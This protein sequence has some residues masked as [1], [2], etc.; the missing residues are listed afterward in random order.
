MLSVVV[1]THH[2]R[3]LGEAV[4]SVLDQTEPDFEI[5][6]VP[7]GD[8]SVDGL[9]PDDSRIRVVP[10]PGHGTLGAIKR[11]GFEAA[12]GDILVELDHDDILAP[13]ALQRVREACA[14]GGAD[15]VYSNFAELNFQT[16]ECVTYDPYW[17][18]KTRSTEVRGRTVT[19]MMAFEPSPASIGRIW[20]APNHVRAWTREAYGRAGGHNPALPVCDDHDLLVRTYLTGRMTRI[21]ECLY[22]QRNHPARTTV[23]HNVDIQRTTEEIYCRSIESLVARW[24]AVSGLPCYQLGGCEHAAPGWV[25]IDRGGQPGVVDLKGRWPWDDS[26]VGAFGALDLLQYLPD[27]Q[28]AMNEMYRCL[29]PG[30]W[31]LSSTPSALGQAAFMDPRICSTWV[32]NSFY[33]WTDATYA[34]HIGNRS[35]GFRLIAWTSRS[36]P[37]GIGP[38]ACPTCTSTGWP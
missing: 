37:T 22:L 2:P 29:A 16:G 4:A 20:Y 12:A 38:S 36:H 28:H 9:L 23:A 1:P 21:D 17:G 7:N 8:A 34:R 31:L 30:G 32:R 10:Y 24:A 26:S 25:T 3:Y 18:W 5:V 27:K 19:E 13:Q 6:I 15:F 35:P 11:F 33:Y 14:D